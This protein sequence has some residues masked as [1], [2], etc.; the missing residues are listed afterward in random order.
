MFLLK[1]LSKKNMAYS[2]KILTFLLAFLFLIDLL[3]LPFMI[4]A[5][6]CQTNFPII[7]TSAPLVNY[8]LTMRSP[9][10]N[11]TF[12]NVMLIDYSLKINSNL[13]TLGTPLSLSVSYR[14]DNNSEVILIGG[15][16][17]IYEF[18]DVT[19]LKDGI[20]QLMLLAQFNYLYNN[21]IYHN[22]QELT[23]TYFQILNKPPTIHILSPKNSIYFTNNVPLAVEI[24]NP[25]SY[26]YQH[27]PLYR[28]G[29]SLDGENTKILD[30]QS[31]NGTLTGLTD[32]FHSLNFYVEIGITTRS[33]STISFLVV[34]T[35]F[36]IILIT[37]IVLVAFLVLILLLLYRRHRKKPLPV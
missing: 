27:Y 22:K 34:A 10:A 35:P 2:R 31:V 13:S 17:Y 25:S 1:I 29:Y 33:S 23:T 7:Q 8:N 3:L 5:V 11:A 32:G 36:S 18:I 14:I 15:D 37:A 28:Q 20:H 19:Y 16:Q 4:P 6:E 24:G 26:G 21:T 9:K 30:Y 12:T